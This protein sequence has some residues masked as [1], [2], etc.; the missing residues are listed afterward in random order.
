MCGDKLGVEL[1]FVRCGQYAESL[2]NMGLSPDRLI[3]F[4]SEGAFSRYVGIVRWSLDGLPLMDFVWDSTDTLRPETRFKLGLLAV[5]ALNN[6]MEGLVD[7]IANEFEALS[8]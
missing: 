4:L 6:Q 2:F 8:G 3:R 7:F 1:Y 5:V